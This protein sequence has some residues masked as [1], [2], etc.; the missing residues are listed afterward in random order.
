MYPEPF[1]PKE[2][3]MIVTIEQ[4]PGMPNGSFTL[5]R[6]IGYTSSNMTR[7]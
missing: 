3:E 2:D 4:T 7:C 6:S 1:P 5:L